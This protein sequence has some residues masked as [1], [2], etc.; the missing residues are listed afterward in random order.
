MKAL[1]HLCVAAGLLVAG[2]ALASGPELV[3]AAL[4]AMD[5]ADP[6]QWAYTETTIE[7]G[8]TRV[9]KHDPTRP[10]GERWML[11]SVDGRAPTEQEK[12][13][14]SERRRSSGGEDGDDDEVGFAATIE[15]GSLSLIEE[16]ATHL[17]YGFD[18]ASEDEED[19]GFNEHLQATLRIAK[20][21][22]YVETLEMKSREPFSPGFSVKIK[23][24]ALL[25]TYSPVGDDRIV[26]PA[27]VTTK[28]A[29]RAMLFKKID[30]NVAVTYSD[31]RYVGGSD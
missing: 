30:E 13:R 4:A 17:I 7:N 10:E 9:A 3:E 5:E 12:E 22:P 8:V 15:P 21:G 2:S 19:R 25:L 24:F 6:R 1:T 31:Y 16:T 26:L 29:G 11:V 18:P 23:E 28:I 27:G 20:G 14:D